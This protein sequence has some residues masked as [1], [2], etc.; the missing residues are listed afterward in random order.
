MKGRDYSG[1][2]WG[3]PEAIHALLFYDD[4]YLSRFRGCFY[5]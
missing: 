3:T 2:D 1:T 5:F 4:L